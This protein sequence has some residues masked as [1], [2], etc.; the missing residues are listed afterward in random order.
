V[1]EERQH[2]QQ[3]ERQSVRD[4]AALCAQ[5]ERLAENVVNGALACEAIDAALAPLSA[6]WIALGEGGGAAAKALEQRYAQATAWFA[7]LQEV[8]LPTEE[9]AAVQQAASAKRHALC[10][11]MEILVGV[12]SPPEYREARLKYQVEHL[13]KHMKS[14]ERRDA[15]AR[16]AEIEAAW[17]ATAALPSASAEGLERRFAGAM[18]RLGMGGH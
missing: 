16:A 13:A 18:K 9:F 17:Y 15:N 8:S 14:G 11:D 4:R 3:R 6:Q 2:A 5:L 12:E 7:R 10:L 1:R